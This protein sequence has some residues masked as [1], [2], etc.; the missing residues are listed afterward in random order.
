VHSPAATHVAQRLSLSL[1]KPGSGGLLGGSFNAAFNPSA[2][3]TSAPPDATT[4]C[5]SKC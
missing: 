2:V 5:H 4:V 1:Q 3:Q